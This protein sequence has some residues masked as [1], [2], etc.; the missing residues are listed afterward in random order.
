MAPQSIRAALV[1]SA[2]LIVFGKASGFL[3]DLA[4]AI[5]FGADRT[6]DVFYV[7]NVVPSL[8]LTAFYTTIPL[9][10]MPF[11]IRFIKERSAED[12]NQFAN[13]VLILYAA[14]TLGI[15]LLTIGLAGPLVGLLAPGLDADSK[16]TAAHFVRL[17]SLSFVFSVASAYFSA[18]QYAHDVRLGQQMSPIINNTIFIIAVI[19]FGQRYGIELAVIAAVA[20]WI[21]QLP[22][23]Y[24]FASGQFRFVRPSLTIP[25]E[26]RDLAKFSAPVFLATF[27]EQ[28]IAANA[29]YFSSGLPEG[30]VSVLNYA[31]KLANLPLALAALLITIYIYPR[32]IRLADKSRQQEFID[33]STRALKL[34]VLLGLPVIFACCFEAS[35][36]AHA[37]FS[38]SKLSSAEIY[39]QCL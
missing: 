23:Q 37:A 38:F 18:I 16:A 10:F 11:Y 5:T 17:F 7:A 13:T 33:F 14:I 31:N 2:F 34:S 22:L 15:T 21:V 26:L 35:L 6:T 19:A 12:A 3:R 4:M 29:V 24:Y 32:L 25:P 9:S 1:V 30:S 28:G 27:F 36:I 8:C 39:L 20:G